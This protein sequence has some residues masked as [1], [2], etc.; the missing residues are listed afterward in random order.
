MLFYFGLSCLYDSH[1]RSSDQKEARAFLG[2]LPKCGFSEQRP[3][4]LPSL[5]E[6]RH[7]E[8]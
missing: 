4:L 6:I 5:E 2:D 7:V 3:A 1:K 8:W